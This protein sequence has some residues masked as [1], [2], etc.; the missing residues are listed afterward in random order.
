MTA[1]VASGWS[2]CRAGLAPTGKRR[3]STAHANCRLMHRSK[4]P[5]AQK[6]VIP[7]LGVNP[8]GPA[9]RANVQNPFGR[10]GNRSRLSV[11][12]T[13]GAS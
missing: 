12:A 6:P 10:A 3:L 9:A 7:W 11:A 13:S 8:G 1:P 4:N 2:G 5:N